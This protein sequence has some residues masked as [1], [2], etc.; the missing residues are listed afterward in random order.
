MKLAKPGCEQSP[1]KSGETHDKESYPKRGV[2]FDTVHNRG[3]LLFIQ[4]V[5]V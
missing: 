2:E 5:I 1:S 4:E 3:S